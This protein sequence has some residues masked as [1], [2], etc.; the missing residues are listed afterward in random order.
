MAKIQVYF[1]LLLISFAVIHVASA[2]PTKKYVGVYELKK[3]N[4]SVKITNWGAT[5][6]SVILPD[7]KGLDFGEKF[8]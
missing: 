1:G 7:S 5:V 3:G 6:I 2:T 4:F 8:G